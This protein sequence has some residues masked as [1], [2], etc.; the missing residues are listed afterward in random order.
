MQ[1][2]TYD[3]W[4][5]N[6]YQ[7]MVDSGGHIKLDC[8]DCDASGAT[9]CRCCGHDS[10]CET[11][12][13]DGYLSEQVNAVSED[14]I[15]K[16]YKPNG[17]EYFENMVETFSDLAQLQHKPLIDVIGPFIYYYRKN[18]HNMGE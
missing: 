12:D 1:F 13:G 3:Q 15:K 18:Q 7:Q 14:E 11:C 10:D 16:L 2:V 5:I 4:R 9:E 17:Y 8:P 6:R